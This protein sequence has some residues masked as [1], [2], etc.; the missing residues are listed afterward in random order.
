M[1]GSS[2]SGG[3]I[4]NV[5]GFVLL[6]IFEDKNPRVANCPWP[7]L[8]IE[9]DD[10]RELVEG[11]LLGQSA[12]FVTL[13]RRYQGLVFHVVGSLMTNPADR[14]EL[15]QETF[16][17]VFRKLHTFEH[18]SLKAWIARVARNVTLNHLRRR[19][20]CQDQVT[21]SL[22][23]DHVQAMDVAAG[24]MPPADAR[25]MNDHLLGAVE[26]IPR[27][28]SDIVKLYYFEE[29]TISEIGAVLQMPVGTVKS[30][31][32]R[33]RRLLKRRIE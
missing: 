25:L 2:S 13:V 28:A 33:A 11:V 20:I 3:V 16:L 1:G 24:E 21:E 30:H 31:L 32:F 17:R 18:G 19:A 23:P 7:V 5:S 22:S 8:S 10:E 6:R 4:W 9:V 27:P 15:C 12:P 29:L 14:E 26:A